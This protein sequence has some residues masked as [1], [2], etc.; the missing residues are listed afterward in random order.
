[1]A[2]HMLRHLLDNQDLDQQIHTQWTGPGD[3]L[4]LLLLVGGDVVQ[5]AIAQ[6][7]G[8]S[9]PTPVVFSFGW[10]AYAF[11]G[12]LS[13]VGDNLLMPPPDISCIVISTTLGYARPNRSW[14]LGRILRDFELNGLTKK[15]RQALSDLLKKHQVPKKSLCVSIWEPMLNAQPKTPIKDWVW[16]SGYVIMVLQLFLASVAWEYWGDWIVFVITLGGTAL[17]LLTSSLPQWR[18]ERWPCREATTKSFVLCR[19]NGCQHALAI[20]GN[21]AGID[22]EDLA[23]TGEGATTEAYTRVVMGLLTAGWVSLLITVSGVKTQTWFL[24]GIGAIG[25]VH[26]VFVAGKSRS[27]SAFG[28]HLTPHDYVLEEDVMKTLKEVERRYPGIGISMLSTFFPGELK[29]AQEI[30]YWKEQK[31]TK[32]SRY[33]QWKESKQPSKQPNP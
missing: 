25:M 27:P 26:T 16:W 10:V 24:L 1:M 22:L 6:Q 18:R 23:S 5:R 14:I 28:I 21:G 7:A 29:D 9:L 31:E 2:S 19:G 13:A 8:S 12:L 20:Y 15:A 33:A 32:K 3:I 11:T 4:S 30:Q 17:A